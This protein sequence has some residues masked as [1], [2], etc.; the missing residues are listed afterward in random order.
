MLD[1]N[2]CPPI[3]RLMD[4]LYCH[5]EIEV[6]DSQV[7]VAFKGEGCVCVWEGGVRK[8]ME[9]LNT[10]RGNRS[11][12][13]TPARGSEGGGRGLRGAEGGGKQAV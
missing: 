5:G 8:E 7:R 2:L 13:G 4:F 10:C 11:P 9:M 3:K 12:G 6:D 1:S